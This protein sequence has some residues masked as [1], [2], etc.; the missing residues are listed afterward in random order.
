MHE[1]FKKFFLALGISN[2]ILNNEIID[3]DSSATI[4]INKKLTYL[5]ILTKSK[6]YQRK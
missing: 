3:P 4:L 6:S 5:M 1:I 2:L